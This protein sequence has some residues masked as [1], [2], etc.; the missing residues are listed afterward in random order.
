MTFWKRSVKETTPEQPTK[1]IMF[2][3]F[4]KNCK[5]KVQQSKN[6][7]S[8]CFPKKHCNKH[9]IR[10]ITKQIQYCANQNSDRNCKRGATKQIYSYCVHRKCTES[11]TEQQT[12]KLICCVNKT[13]NRNW[14]T[15]IF[16]FLY[17]LTAFFVFTQE[18]WN[19]NNNAKT[20]T[21]FNVFV[22]FV[23]RLNKK[24]HN[25][26]GI[27]YKVNEGSHDENHFVSTLQHFLA[28]VFVYF[29][30]LAAF[31]HEHIR[32]CCKEKKRNEKF[33]SSCKL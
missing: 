21:C 17:Y 18:C 14:S 29:L 10:A 22:D 23:V 24:M 7:G 16:V 30:A 11:T 9:Y 1:F 5:R 19:S 8:H 27:M 12:S 15:M 31:F 13:C 32:K 3:C 4:L 20:N 33:F 25:T 2:H 6:N 26:F 28:L